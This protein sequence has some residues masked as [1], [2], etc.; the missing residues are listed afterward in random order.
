MLEFEI[1]QFSTI[2]LGLHLA[3]ALFI[4]VSWAVEIAVFKADKSVIDGR[5]GWHFGLVCFSLLLTAL[6][7]NPQFCFPPT[8]ESTDQEP[9]D[10]EPADQELATIYGNKMANSNESSASSPSRPSYSS[11]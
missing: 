8:P 11:P 9:A 4:F 7:T 6:S 2:K 10:Q 3:Q 5:V 1:H